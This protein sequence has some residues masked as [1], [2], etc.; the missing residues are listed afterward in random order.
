MRS[1]KA[2]PTRIATDGAAV[3]PVARQF[4]ISGRVQGVFF[5]DSTRRIAQPLGITGHAINLPN[6]DVEV[7]AYGDESAI[8]RLTDWLQDGPRMAE[9]RRVDIEDIDWQDVGGFRTG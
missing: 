8:D 9:V 2:R 7:V 3:V 1:G 6:G 4:R 5:R